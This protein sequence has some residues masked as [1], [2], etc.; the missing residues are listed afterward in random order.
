M[1][2]LRWCIN[3]PVAVNLLVVFLVIAGALAL[4]RMPR[5]LFP[6]FSL[7][8][9][10]ISVVFPGANPEEVEE[11]ICIK[12]EEA[13]TGLAGIKRV[14]STARD[15][16]GTVI[17]ELE[18]GE[19]I[20]RVKDEIETRVNGINTFPRDAEKPVVKKLELVRQ[21]LQVAVSGPLDEAGLRDL[22][23]A[24]RKDLL[25]MREISQV[26]LDGVKNFEISLEV[27]EARLREFGLTFDEVARAVR[28]NSLDLSG[29]VARTAAG[30]IL[31]RV[32]GQRYVRREFEDIV[33][34]S[35]ATGADV[36]LHQVA[37]VV[38]GFADEQ[39]Q[40]RFDGQPAAFLGV[41]KTENEDIIAIARRVREYVRERQATLPA[42]V[43]LEVIND[44]SRA[45][46]DRL[47]LLKTNGLQGLLL[48]ILTLWFF[49][50]VELSFWVGI[51][52]PISFL[53]TFL[54]LH[55]LGQSLNMMSMFG[56]IMALGMIVDD[57]IVVSESTYAQMERDP[58]LTPPQ[59]ALVGTSRVFWP[60]VASVST[61]VVA[62]LP[63]LV[64][65]GIMGKFIA[66]LPITVS[67]ALIV[68]L[69]EGLVSLPC[70]LAHHLS[71]P[72]KAEARASRLRRWTEGLIRGCIEVYGIVLRRAVTWKYVTVGCCIFLLLGMI[73]VARAGWVPFVLFSRND[74][75]V[76]LARVSF[77]EGTPFAVTRDAVSRIEAALASVNADLTREYGLAS[78]AVQHTYA[79]VGQWSGFEPTAGANRG[80]VTVELLPG[81]ERDFFS[82]EVLA[83]W[84]AATGAI[85][86]ALSLT[87]E[88]RE[89]G[90]GGKPI[91]I[92]F[93]GD[94]FAALRGA[95]TDLKHHLGT[96]PGVYDIQ[97][98][99]KAGTTELRLDLKPSARSL[100]LTLFDLASQVRHAFY[101]N[102]ALRLQRGRF[103]VKVFI[104]YT[105]EERRFLSS[106]EQMVVRT[107]GG[108]EIPLSEVA[109][110][111]LTE[112]TSEI[113]RVD[114]QRVIQV[115]ADVNERQTNAA[116]ISNTLVES[117][118]LPG[119][120][121][122]HGVTFAFEGQKK[123][124]MESLQG[125]R[126][127]FLIALLGIYII[128]ATI[129]SS[130]VQ[131][132]II[133]VSIPFGIIG[134][135][136]GH[137]VM[138]YPLTMMSMFGLV[139]L[140]GIVVNNALLIIDF[141][142]EGINRG[143]PL[144]AAVVEAGQQRIRPILLTSL[145]TIFG[146]SSLMFGQSFQAQFLIPMA[147][148]L[149]WGLFVSTFTTLFLVSSLY[150]VLME[151]GALLLSFWR[152]RWITAD[153]M[154]EGM[155]PVLADLPRADED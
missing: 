112:G 103:D 124:S 125:L 9:V 145:T 141:I 99:F 144:E 98:N 80:E 83:R 152:W 26:T 57:A 65:T 121:R 95:V 22:V 111:R 32:K 25:A 52:I 67:A 27:S 38:D 120:E 76:V 56:L 23:E 96:F 28:A 117:G 49:M 61:T 77:P 45:V 47:N 34:R 91:E 62:F 133:M 69:I 87:F 94:S 64:V 116:A 142:N 134:A 4:D 59:A 82:G 8:R 107:P 17:A 16:V 146:V 72:R 81:E 108:A 106:L 6:T 113:K 29:G 5:E 37:R 20:D 154:L 97:D 39:L 155:R 12:I 132:I 46:N 41:F 70:H 101:G 71:P 63:L 129:F 139:A 150:V 127:G 15:S 93:R 109:D 118:F 128:L 3:N 151:W 104:R 35:E 7:D 115:L 14:S 11:G 136:L 55:L 60:V 75:D 18:A 92:Q 66:V 51:G 42:G 90:P 30:E 137:W 84:R 138:G 126:T 89:G 2:V 86:G 119:L 114:G 48:V 13:L 105:Q 24:M 50:N 58:G 43:K 44:L 21:V 10:M 148:S 33:V 74:S 68:S 122:R 100:G 85:P 31:L 149:A 88:E 79:I 147:I 123:E 140:S 73:G 53:G 110:V 36:A 40:A 102:E 153:E 54:L 130:Y 19:N 1:A 135:L 78:D 131:P 143:L